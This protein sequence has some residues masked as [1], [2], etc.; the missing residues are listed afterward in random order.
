MRTGVVI[1]NAVHFLVETSGVANVLECMMVD[2]CTGMKVVQCMVLLVVD[3][4][5]GVKVVQ[6]TEHVLMYL[7]NPANMLFHYTCE[8]VKSLLKLTVLQK[9]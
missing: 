5:T 8:L 4:A 1:Q 6:N 3:L 2:L 9:I 7:C